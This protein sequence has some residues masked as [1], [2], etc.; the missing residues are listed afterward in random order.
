MDR[1]LVIGATGQLGRAAI[2]K[3]KDRA[4]CIRALVRQPDSAACFQ[5]LG[6]EPVLGDLTDSSSLARACDGISTVIATANAAIPTRRTDTFEAVERD[7]YRNLIQAAVAARVRRFV[8]TSAPL[9]K[10]EHLS[11]LLRFKRETEQALTSS[12]LDHVI[13][14]ADVFMDTAF[15]M[16]GSTIPLC[17]SDG[18]TVLRPFAFA[19][20]HFA[21][22]KDSIE[23]KHVALVPGDGTSHHTFI[24]VDD[25]AEFLAAAAHSG[26]SGSFAIGGPEPLTFLDIVRLYERILGANLKVQH[27]PARVFRTAALLMRP[28]SPPAANLM[29]LNY[30]GAVEDSVADPA[31]APAFGVKL[32]SAETFLRGKHAL[33]ATLVA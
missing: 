31:S 15:T 11:P 21:R 20:R 19:N 33:A 30:I 10:Y 17:G 9:S 14:R 7:G 4:A 18:A 32:T 25:V 12:G 2:R 13:F 26:P 22:I 8:Y 5:S 24:C 27:A 28:F 23:R 6:I 3:L 29:A 1:V 16:M